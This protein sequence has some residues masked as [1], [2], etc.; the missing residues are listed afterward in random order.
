[1]LKILSLTILSILCSLTLLAQT[2]GNWT[3]I[4]ITS[5]N[6][7]ATGFG[8]V[9]NL[10]FA[11]D[12]N[13]EVHK[14]ADNGAT[15]Q[16]CSIT[17]SL[18]AP[19][20]VSGSITVK[21]APANNYYFMCWD[22]Q[23]FYSADNGSTWVVLPMNQS[24]Y[25][26]Y[27]IYNDSLFFSYSGGNVKLSIYDAGNAT[28]NPTPVTN[29]KAFT[30]TSSNY[31]SYNYTGGSI[32]LE[33]SPN[34]IY[35]GTDITNFLPV[36]Q[37]L[38][39]LNAKGDTLFINDNYNNKYYFSI[40]QGNSWSLFYDYGAGGAL[41]AFMAITSNYIYV[42][43]MTAGGTY[44]DLKC[45]SD[46]GITW[47]SVPIGSSNT[48]NGI[49]NDKLIVLGTW[50]NPITLY[51][52][53]ANIPDVINLT[54][55]HWN[56]YFSFVRQSQNK[57]LVS[58]TNA[59][60]YSTIHLS[61]DNGNSYNDITANANFLSGPS[62]AVLTSQVIILNQT[63]G[64]SIK[65]YD[66]GLT[67][68]NCQPYA[69]FISK[70]D[71]VYG[72]K[73][74]AT[75]KVYYSYNGGLTFDSVTVSRNYYNGI[76]MNGGYITYN[77]A[78]GT[79]FSFFSN[80]TKTTTTFNAAFF[81]GGN[82]FNAIDFAGKRLLI[83][84]NY[85]DVKIGYSTDNFQ[86]I[87]Q[88]TV[89]S[90]NNILPTAVYEENGNLIIAYSSGYLLSA[91]GI[92]FNDMSYAD[93]CINA[94]VWYDN[95]KKM[96]CKHIYNAGIVNYVEST[97]LYLQTIPQNCTAQFTL[98]ADTIPYHYFVLNQSTGSGNMTYA[99]N[100]G[101]GT[102]VSTGLTPSHTYAVGGFYTICLTIEDGLGCT[103]SN[104]D[105]STLV[106]QSANAMIVVN[107]VTQLP[108][109]LGTNEK[110]NNTDDFIIFPNPGSGL[111]LFKDNS[112]IEKVEVF[113]ITG[114]LILSQGN[115]KQINLSDFP[116]G[117]YFAKINGYVFLKLLKE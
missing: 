6:T 11:L 104:C 116:K 99:W 71:T 45:S 15:W 32:S 96:A 7:V 9:N 43:M 78:L 73:L 5:T 38:G 36:S 77:L 65:S 83:T 41:G 22:G 87:Q 62:S 49:C 70:G 29:L 68:S 42:F 69:T 3:D 63:S 101:D 91:D 40:D 81:A 18:L 14:S 80:V 31:F 28:I 58:S 112:Q 61:L 85:G 92:T 56:N 100:W 26:L 88:S 107:V 79:D 90:A 8:C 17:F 34:G 76:C 23:Q 35:N 10:L 13:S 74:G 37:N 72:Y 20:P 47:Q 111:F 97:Y 86:T 60:G 25:E 95:S 105:T 66:N 106:R 55:S 115:S 84:D 94:V 117:I 89:N 102:A 24:A 4:S 39:G 21:Y 108:A 19:M 75:V 50:T 51:E 52:I 82:N 67:W 46:G 2:C 113:N 93:T 27:Y 103:D 33:R 54:D 44:T 114:E 109:Y 98:V 16:Q 64:T 48:S 57:I 1:M 110:I 30:Q 53:T 12:N 59:A